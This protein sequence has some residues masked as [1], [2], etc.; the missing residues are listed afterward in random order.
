MVGWTSGVRGVAA[1][2]NCETGGASVPA[3]R[4]LSIPETPAPGSF[5]PTIDGDITIAAKVSAANKGNP[6]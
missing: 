1:A 4:R 6:R 5:A 3:S 2:E